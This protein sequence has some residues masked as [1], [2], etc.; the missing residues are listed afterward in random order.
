[1]SSQFRIFLALIIC[2]TAALRSA[3]TGPR[4]SSLCN[5]QKTVAAGEHSIVRISGIYTKRLETSELDDPAC[6]VVPYGSTWVEL[7]LES[8]QNQKKL[9]QLLEKS[10]RASV[11]FDGEF[12][13]SPLPDP[14]LPSGLQ[15]GFPPHWGHLNCCLTKIVVHAIRE[16]TS[17]PP[18]KP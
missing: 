5:L 10:G 3:I 15:N 14:K 6:A 4:M 18:E 2:L 1:M 9:S 16:V 17:A 12:Y 11:V 13:G 8:Q 7:S